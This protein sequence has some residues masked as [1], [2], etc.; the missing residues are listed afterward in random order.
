MMTYELNFIEKKL[1]QR[2]AQQDAINQCFVDVQNKQNETLSP[3][4]LRE[5]SAF[6]SKRDNYLANHRVIALFPNRKGRLRRQ[7]KKMS[8]ALSTLNSRINGLDYEIYC[9]K[10][11]IDQE[12]HKY[13]EMINKAYQKNLFHKAKLYENRWLLMNEQMTEL[14]NQKQTLKKALY[15]EQKR[16]IEQA[17][18]VLQAKRSK[19]L[20]KIRYYCES[21]KMINPDISLML[22]DEEAINKMG[23]DFHLF[24]KDCFKGDYENEVV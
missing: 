8:Y 6:T 5:V 16:L 24:N 20:L 2:K 18:F 22:F 23:L 4:I 7:Y 21:A 19:V 10:Q 1:I 12:Q 14:I 9:Q 13:E 3:F 15:A 11:K 17:R